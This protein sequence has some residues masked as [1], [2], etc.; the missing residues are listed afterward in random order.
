MEDQNNQQNN[1]IRFLGSS[2]NQI[3]Y[4]AQ[5]DIPKSKFFKME[6]LEIFQFK[7]FQEPKKFFKIQQ[8]L[9][10]HSSIILV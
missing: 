2:Y 4:M 10:V 9:N 7:L 8:N 6:H 3:Q 1:Q 5:F